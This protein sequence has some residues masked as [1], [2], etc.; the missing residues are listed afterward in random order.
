MKYDSAEIQSEDGSVMSETLP[1]KKTTAVKEKL[2]K[3]KGEDASPAV[4]RKRMQQL[5]KAVQSYQVRV[6]I[7]HS[8]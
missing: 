3:K 2:K 7:S 4:L 8:V 5:Y 1:K 6:L